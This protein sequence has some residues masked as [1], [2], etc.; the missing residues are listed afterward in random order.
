MSTKSS[1][2]YNEETDIHIYREMY[3]DCYY[4]SCSFSKMKI[5]DKKLIIELEKAYDKVHN[6]VKNEKI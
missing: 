5:T 4:I 3:D 1:I 2:I 6:V